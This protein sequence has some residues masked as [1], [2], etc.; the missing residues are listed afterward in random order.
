MTATVIEWA[1]DRQELREEID[2]RHDPDH[3]DEKCDLGPARHGRVLAQDLGGGD[4]GGEELGHLSHQPV[5]KARG[6]QHHQDA[7]DRPQH[8]GCSRQEEESLHL[9]DRS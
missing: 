8:Q 3:R 4:A 1:D 5:G 6:E 2:R 9:S 7:A